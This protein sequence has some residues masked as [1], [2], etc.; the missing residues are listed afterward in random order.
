[1]LHCVLEVLYLHDLQLQPLQL[2][3]LLCN[4]SASIS[5][6]PP[7]PYLSIYTPAIHYHH[8]PITKTTLLPPYTSSLQVDT[9]QGAAVAYD[10]ALDT[11]LPKDTTGNLRKRQRNF[12]NRRSRDEAI[13]ESKIEES[14]IEEKVLAIY[15]G[16]WATGSTGSIV[17]AK[18]GSVQQ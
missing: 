15:E 5:M 10:V 13:E 7:S 12:E 16:Q 8:K 17:Q 9:A 18:W 2:L 4:C 6:L 11:L 3:L 14:V 1:M